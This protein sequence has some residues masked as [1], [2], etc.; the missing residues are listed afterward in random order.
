MN[1]EFFI[2]NQWD[3]VVTPIIF[4]LVFMIC[5]LIQK[6]KEFKDSRYK[7][8][9]TGMVAKLF[10]AIAIS[11]VYQFYYKMGG[12]T[13]N[14]FLTGKALSYLMINSPGRYLEIMMCDRVPVEKLHYFNFDYAYPVYWKDKHAFFVSKLISPIVLVSFNSYLTAATLLSGLCYTG[15]WRLYLLFTSYFPQLKRE[16]AISILYFPSV[17]FWGSGILKDTI[18]YAA[19]GWYVFGFYYLFVQRRFNVLYYLSIIIASYLL[20]SIKPYIFM[21]LVPGSLFWLTSL[22]TKKIKNQM[23][24]VIVGPVFVL[25]GLIG[26]YL[27]LESMGNSLGDYRLD[28]LIDIALVKQGDLK[29]SYYGGNSFDVGEVDMSVWGFIKVMPEAIASTFF[30]PFLWEVKNPVMLLSA[31]ENTFLMILT[32]FLLIKLR[33]YIFFKLIRHHPL[34]QFSMLFSLFFA[35]AVGFS[36]PNF[37]ALVR[38][39][40]PC[41]PFFVAS[42]FIIR[43][44]YQQK[45]HDYLIGK[46]QGATNELQA[47]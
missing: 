31:V 17:V 14:Y 28:N 3:I 13:L 38:L 26:G 29:Q 32:I 44:F 35:F 41:I 22:W 36:T 1:S 15:A 8:F 20:L 45:Q 21:A 4:L 9:T 11:M 2:L 37:G 27:T 42:L 12:D 23:V 43:Y 5:N 16:L 7:Y 19:L 6:R 30:R 24:R 34:V 10:G 25:M 47:L 39:K 33:I 18:T 46:T 40:I